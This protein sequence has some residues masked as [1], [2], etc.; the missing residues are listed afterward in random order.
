MNRRIAFAAGLIALGTLAGCSRTDNP[1]AP[2]AGNG[3]RYGTSPAASSSGAAS[4]S[5]ASDTTT[6]PTTS[7]VVF[8]SGG[9]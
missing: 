4:S 7:D 8:T 1:L 2:T 3:A 6:A 9:N 5:A